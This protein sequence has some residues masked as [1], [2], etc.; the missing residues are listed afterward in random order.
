MNRCILA[1]LILAGGLRCLA[2][3]PRYLALADSADNYIKREKWERAEETI[4]KALRLEPGNFS[5]SLLLSNLGIVQTRQGKLEE[6]LESFR[7]GLSIAPRSS[8]IRT[9]RA[10]TLLQ[11]GR[12]EDAL[13]DLNE[14]L[15]IDSLQ[16]WPLQV[17]GRLLISSDPEEARKN[18]ETLKRHYPSNPASR[19]GL[20]ALAEKEGKGDEALRLYAEALG[21]EDDPDT[22]FMRILLEINMNRYSEASEE[23][24]DAIKAYPTNGDFHILRGLLHRLQYRYDEAKIDKKIA[25]DKGSDRQLVEEILPGL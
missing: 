19:T 1:L 10:R 17:R 16:E 2:S 23:I 13:S 24:S 11:L 21:M 15:S 7:L 25:I 3:S 12:Y 18:F 9:N 5:N 8:V 6:A 4:L 20:A 14:T 22:R